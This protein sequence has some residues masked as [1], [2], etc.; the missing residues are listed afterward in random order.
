MGNGASCA[1]KLDGSENKSVFRCVNGRWGGKV[2]GAVQPVQR[3]EAAPGSSSQP[4]LAEQRQQ[5]RLTE[6]G[7]GRGLL[8]A[9]FS[10]DAAVPYLVFPELSMAME[11]PGGSSRA[12]RTVFLLLNRE[13]L[14]TQ[15]RN[16]KKTKQQNQKKS[17]KQSWPPALFF[18]ALL[19][20]T[21]PLVHFSS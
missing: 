3:R 4:W 18:S 20:V 7:P 12:L 10:T 17:S 14:T 13:I 9:G 5:P 19:F 2:A 8:P 21:K 15:C 16:K 1:A 6:L 11:S